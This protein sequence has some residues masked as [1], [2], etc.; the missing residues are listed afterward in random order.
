MLCTLCENCFNVGGV[1][2]GVLRSICRRRR[3]LGFSG[4]HLR[5]PLLSALPVL[6]SRPFIFEPAH[7]FDFIGPTNFLK[8]AFL[9]EALDLTLKLA[10]LSALKLLLPKLFSSFDG[11]KS[12]FVVW[13]Q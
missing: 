3:F 12:C 6:L 11:F 5:L 10:A 8:P 1:F 9:H 13:L 4:L 2:L 7:S